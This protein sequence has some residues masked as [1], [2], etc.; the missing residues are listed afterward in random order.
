MGKKYL[1]SFFCREYIF[2]NF[3]ACNLLITINII[4]LKK[5]TLLAFCL[6]GIFFSASAQTSNHTHSGKNRCGTMEH[7]EYQMKTIPGF[8]EQFEKNQAALEQRIANNPVARTSATIND[9][10]A[11]VIHVIATAANQTLITDAILQS[12]IDIL[13]EDF[14][15]RN[16][17]STRIPAAFK[18]LFAHS[19]IHFKLAQTS[20]SGTPTN[21]IER[22][23]STTTYTVA[24]GDN[25]KK[26]A[27]GGLDAWNTLQY[28]NLWVV[29]F[30]DGTLGYSVFPG[31]PGPGG[32]TDYTLHG[33]EADYRAFGRGAAFLYPEYNL[34]RTCTH[35]LGHYWNLRHIWGDDGTS[36]AGTDF[37]ATVYGA[38]TDDT[39]NQA[40]ATFGNP[41]VPGTG[42]VKT[43]ACSAAAPGIMYQN[44]MDYSDDI[45]LV[46]FTNGQLS[47]MESAIQNAPDRG[48]V[49]T[50]T[51]YNPPVV[52]PYNA[53]IGITAPTNGQSFCSGATIVP[54]V[55]LSNFGSNTLTTAT[56][57]VTVD[58]TAQAPYT[59][60]GSIAQNGTANVTLPALPTTLTGGAHTIVI[61]VALP[62]GQTDGNPS[63]NSQ[64][65]S[66]TIATGSGLPYTQDFSSATFPPTGLTVF[67]PNSNNTWVRS[68]AGG[69][70][71]FIDNWTA[72]FTNQID[73]LRTLPL[74]VG[75][76]STRIA[77][78]LAHKSY[79]ASPTSTLQDTLA[80]L[81]SKDC[82]ATWTQVYKKWGVAGIAAGTPGIAG[83]GTG[84]P[85]NS[86]ANFTAPAAADWRTETIELTS[87]VTGTGNIIVAFRNTAK[88]GNNIFIDNINIAPV[89]N[90]DLQVSAVVSPTAQLC[91]NTFTPVVTLK[92]N[93]VEAI[94]SD[95]IR[96]TI[97]PGGL[98]AKL[99]YNTA[100]APGATANVT[101][102]AV[103]GL[104]VGSYTIA[105]TADVADVK[106]AT[107]TG[108][109]V[110]GN[111]TLSRTFAIR[112]I[113]TSPLTEGFEGAFA[114]A[115]WAVQNPDNNVEW[116]KGAVGHNSASSALFN[117]YDVNNLGSV[118]RLVTPP[119]KSTGTG[120][121]SLAV[122]F[123]LAYAI[124]EEAAGT[125]TDALAV[126]Y[127][128]D[129][130]NTWIP[131]TYN[132]TGPAL[133]TAPSSQDPFV[134]TNSQWR[135]ERVTVGGAAL[136]S[137]SVLFAFQNTSGYAQNLYIDNV[138]ILPVFQQDLR[139]VS[140]DQPANISCNSS[141]TPVITV[142]NNGSK[143]ITG[144]RAN[145]Q[146]NGGAAVATTFTGLNIAPGVTY[147]ATLT[148]LS[149]I[150]SGQNSIKVYTDNLTTAVG[151]GD[152][153]TVNDTLS[154]S[155]SSLSV[156]IDAPLVEDFQGAAFTP[157][158]WGV[159]NP[160]GSVTWAKANVGHNSSS[161]AVV[162]NFNYE[163]NGSKDDLYSPKV[164]YVIA[165]S[166]YLTFDV[167]AA[168]K[169]YPGSTGL[170]TDT[171][172]VLITKDCGATF[173]SV[174]KKWGADLQTLNDPNNGLATEFV[175]NSASQWRTETVNLLAYRA[176]GPIQFV[177]RN[178]N[179]NGN[180]I[181]I[182]NVNFATKLLPLTLKE[183]GFMI[184]PNPVSNTFTIQQ[185]ETAA[186]LRSVGVYDAAGRQLQAWHYNGNAS[187]TITV[188]MAKY[189]A[190]TYTVKLTYSNKVIAK[191]IVKL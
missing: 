88:Y 104:A 6:L 11:V 138:N 83:L 184:S 133:A 121:D 154:K 41:D 188:N 141:T 20:P 17:D 57:N 54:T 9:T 144:F 168:T 111:N 78:D 140:I 109:Q 172:E 65:I 23:T 143:N 67:N 117:N 148:L 175:P 72:D 180:N 12:Q 169:V 136:A 190:G 142:R 44:Y 81:I 19:G 191:R 170:A 5:F 21:G 126:V 115:N 181:Y 86:T 26:T 60:N 159:D 166:A 69:G 162:K 157:A 105:F 47:R 178:T 30:T 101:F 137:G 128:T 179:N 55:V 56:I 131:T 35:E 163:G 73:E 134:P 82:G 189:A 80:V 40:G 176:N 185:Y 183:N 59:F 90:R 64:T 3:N 75:T 173:T 50:S 36:C 113:V 39:P 98:T 29:T 107:G 43:D 116:T 158:N 31:T 10:V 187:N 161:S 93:G 42:T 7:L 122:E 123:D 68:A 16:A 171:L 110:A 24:T 97:T 165:D 95:T 145:Y 146:L 8:K 63:N 77:F 91:T 28:L 74:T 14:Q 46:M 53:A 2:I 149:N 62:A 182:D 152:Q 120:M 114:P 151:N 66:I 58:G 27:N 76:T 112:T 70:S 103:T 87:A 130:G 164:N 48:P 174:Y 153:N 49:F 139:V 150:P 37:P 96:Y 127:S 100:I 108:D 186:N 167:A 25:A 156:A 34:G 84:T 85:R 71:A 92:N 18:P 102:P 45:A 119:I 61:S 155:F 15:G 125:A 135:R 147:S 106:S 38:G 32:A 177:F 33:F 160:D 22:K 129:C 89:V 51:A 4:A 94:I 52:Y 118:D 79:S 124:Y 99:F 13:N 1:T 132:K